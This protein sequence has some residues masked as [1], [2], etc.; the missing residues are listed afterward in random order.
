MAAW[1]IAL[2]TAIGG[3]TPFFVRLGTVICATATLLV[4]FTTTRV[5]FGS[6]R[7]GLPELTRK[8]RAMKAGMGQGAFVFSDDYPIML[9][10]I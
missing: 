2:F 8:A 7:L 4:L 5:L 3:D 9:A 1:T 10:R 6:A